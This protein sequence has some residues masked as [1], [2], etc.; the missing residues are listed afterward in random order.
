[1]PPTVPKASPAEP[2][3]KAG[4]YIIDDMMVGAVIVSGPGV[5][6]G[7]AMFAQGDINVVSDGLGRAPVSSYF[8]LTNGVGGPQLVGFSANDMAAGAFTRRLSVPFAN[9]VVAATI[10]KRSRWSITTV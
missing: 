5:I 2:A 8:A 3:G 4:C 7:I 6:T 9:G 1:M 10:P